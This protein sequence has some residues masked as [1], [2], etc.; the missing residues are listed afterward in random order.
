[1][2]HSVRCSTS[3]VYV[4]MT[5]HLRAGHKKEFPPPKPPYSVFDK[6]EVEAKVVSLYSVNHSSVR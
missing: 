2:R 6:A 4:F 3:L 1:M 5:C